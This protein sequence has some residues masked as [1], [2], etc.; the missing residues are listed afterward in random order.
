MCFP[1][2]WGTD[3]NI[4]SPQNRHLYQFY[5]DLRRITPG[6]TANTFTTAIDMKKSIFTTFEKLGRK[7][8]ILLNHFRQTLRRGQ[9]VLVI[10]DDVCDFIQN[11]NVLK[12]NRIVIADEKCFESKTKWRVC[13]RK[14][15]GLEVRTANNVSFLCSVRMLLYYVQPKCAS[16]GLH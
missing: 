14:F 8:S 16:I 4:L 13:L 11:L 10:T 12:R 7:F 6:T 3:L 2:E 1:Q 15:L 5:Q 9:R